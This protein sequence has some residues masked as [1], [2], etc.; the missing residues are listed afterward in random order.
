MTGLVLLAAGLGWL[1]LID[2]DGSY[3]RSTLS[4]SGLRRTNR[5]RGH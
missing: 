1:A 3:M 2:P 5:I 4:R